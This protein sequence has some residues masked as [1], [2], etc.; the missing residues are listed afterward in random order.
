M[1]NKTKGAIAGLA[2][3]ALLAGGSTFALWT[4]SDTADGGV[5]QTGDLNVAAIDGL[6]WQDVSGDR[7]DSPHDIANIAN[8]QM[9][10]GDTIEGRQ[11]IDVALLGDNLA[12]SLSL[13]KSGAETLPTGISVVYDVVQGETTLVSGNA[14]GSAAVLQLQSAQNP[15]DPAAAGRT[16]V[17]SSL[18]DAADLTVVVRVTFADVGARTSALST[19]S[20]SG[21]SVRLDQV[22]DGYGFQTP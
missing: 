9:V 19:A 17:G 21:L 11:D 2:G 7:T 16:V 14:L 3:L 15:N 5:V 10:P 22:R 12:A 13:T 8:W 18:D 6:T 20:L 4:A 1:R